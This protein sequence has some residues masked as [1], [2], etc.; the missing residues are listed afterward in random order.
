[1]KTYIR[2]GMIDKKTRKGETCFW[3]PEFS[4]IQEEPELK[5]QP[6]LHLQ[7][8]LSHVTCYNVT[9]CPNIRVHLEPI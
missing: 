1:M 9:K 4:N 6:L 2:S 3:N 5:T 7:I 8:F